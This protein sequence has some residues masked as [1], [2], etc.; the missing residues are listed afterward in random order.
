MRCRAFRLV[1]DPTAAATLRLWHLSSPGE[2]NISGLGYYLDEDKTRIYVT[3]RHK[4]H[5]HVPVPVPAAAAATAALPSLSP[6]L[7]LEPISG[8]D[9]RD[10]KKR[11]RHAAAEPAGKPLAPGVIANPDPDASLWCSKAIK[12]LELINH[13]DARLKRMRQPL[14]DCLERIR[15]LQ[16][17]SYEMDGQRRTGL[18][19]QDARLVVPH[20]VRQDESGYLSMNYLDLI[21]YLIGAIKE[22]ADKVTH[23]SPNLANDLCGYREELERVAAAA[24]HWERCKSFMNVAASLL[25][26]VVCGGLLSVFAYFLIVPTVHI[27][28]FGPHGIAAHS[29][30]AWEEARFHGKIPPNSWFATAQAIGTHSI[31]E[32]CN[33][34]LVGARGQVPLSIGLIV[35]IPAFFVGVLLA[36]VG[37]S[38][39]R[40]G[41]CCCCCYNPQ[42]SNLQESDEELPLT[43][44]VEGESV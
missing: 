18:I 7:A 17:E 32:L 44:P 2:R 23:D 34:M 19:A 40:C 33:L 16:P 14:T 11:L 27:A 22:I 26:F 28:G 38:L 9:V 12:A 24:R 39:Y 35:C 3:F 4:P 37:R 30:A 41:C 5:V 10:P 8:V 36:A 25:V 43:S 29:F 31:L 13:S 21:A 42:P 20:V 1:I 6:L 15:Q